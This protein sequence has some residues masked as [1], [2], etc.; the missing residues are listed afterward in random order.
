MTKRE[1]NRLWRQRDRRKYVLEH[2]AIRS[3]RACWTLTPQAHEYLAML[4][5]AR[6]WRRQ[7]ERAMLAT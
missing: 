6:F 2:P 4:R 1:Y 3:A 5:A 7:A